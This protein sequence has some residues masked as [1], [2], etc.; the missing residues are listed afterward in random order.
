[1]HQCLTVPE[2]L[3]HMCSYVRFDATLLSLAITCKAF[4]EPALDTLYCELK[5]F[6]NLL[7]CLPRDI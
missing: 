3:L 5:S 7:R 1:M 2:I 4:R 6:A